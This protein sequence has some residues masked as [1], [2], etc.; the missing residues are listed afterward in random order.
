MKKKVK[1]TERNVQ[2]EYNSARD[3]KRGK[4]KKERQKK[5]GKKCEIT[6]QI[7]RRKTKLQ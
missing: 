4:M 1:A 7:V 2:K 6:I 3:E 5:N